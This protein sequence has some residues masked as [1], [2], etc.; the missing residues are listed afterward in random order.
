MN[1]SNTW[2]IGQNLSSYGC[3][4][5]GKFTFIIH[6]WNDDFVDYFPTLV[7]KFIEHRGGCVIYFNYS[8]CIDNAN[9]F[10]SLN[11][12]PNASAVLTKKLNDMERELISPINILLY[13]HSLGSWV[14]VDGAINF[15]PQKVGLIDCNND[16]IC[17]GY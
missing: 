16:E 15:G 12:W 2:K 1:Q 14:A 3:K 9:Y 10:N 4:A 7:G 5:G 17:V 13:G 8:A 6:G 11:N